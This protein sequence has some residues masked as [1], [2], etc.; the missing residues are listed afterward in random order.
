[1]NDE[2]S[3]VGCCGL[4]CSACAIYQQLIKKRAIQL[5]EVLN[6]YQFQE[7]AKEAKEW[8]PKLAFYPQFEDVLQSLMKM[9]GEYPWLSG[10]WWTTSLRDQR[11]LQGKRIL[12]MRG[13]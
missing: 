2:P 6:A 10:R 11:V 4:Y 1:M 7:I 8:D 9:F 5:L 13:M 3:L 12:H